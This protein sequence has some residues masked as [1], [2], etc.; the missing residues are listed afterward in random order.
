ML[1][2]AWDAEVRT[3]FVPMDRVITRNKEDTIRQEASELLGE[4]LFI[5][6]PLET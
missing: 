4:T 5:Y 1:C 2:C 6:C 3:A